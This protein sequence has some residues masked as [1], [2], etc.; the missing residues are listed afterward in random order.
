MKNT[1]QQSLK[2]K[3]AGRVDMNGGLHSAYVG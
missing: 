3:W 1:T 2:W